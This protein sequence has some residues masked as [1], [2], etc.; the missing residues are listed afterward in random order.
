MFAPEVFGDERS[1]ETVRQLSA[2]DF[3]ERYL[4]PRIPVIVTQA[5][6]NWPARS[7]WE[8]E[9]LKAKYGQQDVLVVDRQG[10]QHQAQFAKYID[11]VLEPTQFQI[12]QGPLYLKDLCLD[13]LPELFEDYSPPDFIDD[14]FTQFPPE[15][16]PPFRWFFIGPATTSSQLHIDTS[17]THAWLTQVQGEKEWRLFPSDH[18]PESYCGA[19][20][21][22]APDV[23]RFPAF[24]QAQC[25]T[26]ILKP[27]ATIFVPCGWRHQVRNLGPSWALTEN[28]FNASNVA[29]VY[30]R[31]I[32]PCMPPILDEVCLAKARQLRAA[33]HEA[34]SLTQSRLLYAFFI[35]R[36]HDLS[37]RLELI[38]SAREL[39]LS[40]A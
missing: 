30:R 39:L 26:A 9:W 25:L 37:A 28:F 27:G 38:R 23:E 24:K 31:T 33:D 34:N 5:T 35:E 32:D 22:F 20:D 1:V 11:Y 2:E 12:P 19:A 7:K 14:W 21:A 17:G 13:F 40:S 36:E 3:F 10:E 18:I 16:R 4:I 8:W 29:D 15:R 6:V